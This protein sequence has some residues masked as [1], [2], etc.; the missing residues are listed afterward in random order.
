MKQA[1]ISELKNHLSQYLSYVEKGGVVRVF[2][3]DR[4]VADIVPIS[5][6]KARGK[7]GDDAWLD[8]LERRGIVR[9]GTG[10]L[11]PG[12]LA[13]PLPRSKSSVTETLIQER[14]EGR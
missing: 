1:K 9:R 4:P 13:R 8:E 5:G 7:A 6:A 12:F 14:R 10:R 2:E 11:P 3:R